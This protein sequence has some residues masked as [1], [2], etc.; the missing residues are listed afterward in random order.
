M[1]SPK[2]LRFPC[3]GIFYS[4]NVTE[5]FA[6]I[7]GAGDAQAFRKAFPADIYIN[8]VSSWRQ[9]WKRKDIGSDFSPGKFKQLLYSISR[10]CRTQRC[11]CKHW[12][13][14]P[15]VQRRNIVLGFAY[16]VYL[17]FYIELLPELTDY[18]QKLN[19]KNV[20]LFFFEGSHLLRPVFC[21]RS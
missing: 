12:S 18:G 19:P 21:F 2:W 17:S 15:L 3:K 16:H 9:V 6:L 11:E 14:R 7:L 20:V 8:D 1:W 4:Q 10:P 5:G 13:Y